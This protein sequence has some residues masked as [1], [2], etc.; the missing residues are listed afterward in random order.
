MSYDN[1][2]TRT[3]DDDADG[4]QADREDR[5]PDCGVGPD[6]AC[7]PECGCQYCRARELRERD[8]EE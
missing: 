5:C 4:E 3:P 1:W 7:A 6:E 8:R 2:K